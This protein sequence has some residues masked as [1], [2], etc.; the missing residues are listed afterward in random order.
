MTYWAGRNVVVT[1]AGGFIGSHLVETLVELGAHATAFVH[2]S[3]TGSWGWLDDSPVKSD[4]RVVPGD[5]CDIETLETAFTGNETVFHLAALI[6]IPYSYQASRSYVRTNIEGT[7]N[8]LQAVAKLGVERMV[9][10]STSEVY[11]TAETTPISEDHPVKGQSPYSASKI[12]ADKL[13]EAFHNSFGTGV[14]TVRPFNTY[15]PRQS[16]RAVVPTIVTQ[17]LSGAAVLR[18]GNVGPTRDLTYVQDTVQ[19]LISAAEDEALVG[20]TLNLGT[21]TEIS[22]KDLAQ[23]IIELTGTSASIEI[24]ARRVRAAGSEVQRLCSDNSKMRRMTGWLP[25]TELDDGLVATIQWLRE[26]LDRYRPEVYAV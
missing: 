14:T 13:V 25:V 7:L 12:G 26:H 16:S 20:E 23:K 15:G 4:V 18:L 24:D 3:S 19:G 8:V 5:I 2:Y 21:G 1:G 22:I 11:G 6:G 9:H 17:C 10:T